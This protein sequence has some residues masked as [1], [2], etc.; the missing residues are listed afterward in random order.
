MTEIRS[1]SSATAPK[2]AD[3]SG[4]P[5][6]FGFA[7]D[8]I[9]RRRSSHGDFSRVPTWNSDFAFFLLLAGG[10]VEFAGQL[11]AAETVDVFGDTAVQG[12]GDA[13]AVFAGFEAALVCGIRDEGNLGED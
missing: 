9:Q 4:P 2:R 1:R 3:T 10:F 11:Y 12:L 8:K 13:L 5:G 7:Q 6:S